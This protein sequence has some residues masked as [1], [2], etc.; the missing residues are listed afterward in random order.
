MQTALFY[1]PSKRTACYTDNS[2]NFLFTENLHHT[3][4]SYSYIYIY[5]C[6]HATYVFLNIV[7]PFARY[8][9]NMLGENAPHFLN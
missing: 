3:V 9:A 6:V 5:L 8:I 4:S 7:Y 1:L 2:D